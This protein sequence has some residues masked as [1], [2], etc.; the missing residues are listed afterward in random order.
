MTIREKIQFR[1]KSLGVK[2]IDVAE[3]V[4]IKTQNP[5]AFLKGNRTLPLPHLEKLC[6]VLG[7]TLGSIDNVYNPNE[8]PNVQREN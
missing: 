5:S 2:Q 8:N 7:L 3:R 6:E 4:G 1:I